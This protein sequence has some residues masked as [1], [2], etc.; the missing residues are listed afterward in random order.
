MRNDRKMLSAPMTKKRG[1]LVGDFVD[2]ASITGLVHI[3]SGVYPGRIIWILI[4]LIFTLLT[5][6]QIANLFFRYD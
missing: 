3:S 2:R 1:E 4:F 6:I 5:G